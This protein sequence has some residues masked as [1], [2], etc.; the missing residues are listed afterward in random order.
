MEDYNTATMPH[1]KYYNF[2]EWEMKEYR[3]KQKKAASKH[4]GD[5][6]ESF[7]DEEQ[8]RREIME[9]RAQAEKREFNELLGKM[10][11][12][13]TRQEDMKRQDRLKIELQ[14]AYRQGDMTTVRRLEKIL[15][16][17]E[18]SGTAVK[19]PWA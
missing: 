19:H 18:D 2:A 3:R 12:N 9:A 6:Q 14:Q 15:A 13:K 5:V 4:A 7:N 16:P 8:R 17:D 10:A 11:S 1:E